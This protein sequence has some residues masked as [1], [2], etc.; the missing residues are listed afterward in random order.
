MPRSHHVQIDLPVSPEEAFAALISP[1]ALCAW[2]SA[3]KAIV[4]PEAGG[5]W[6]AT[7]GEDE[8][9]PDYISGA[10]LSVFEPPHRLVMSNMK[11]VARTGCLHFEADLPTE[12]TI[13][14]TDSSCTLHVH[15]TGFPDDPIADEHYKGCEVGWERTLASLK[16]F[17]S[18]S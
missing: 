10:T 8:D 2:W 16:T 4:V 13:E 12:F 3:S 6:M 17:L 1:S 15:Q 9:A 18:K 11:Y 5:M 14:P 7:W